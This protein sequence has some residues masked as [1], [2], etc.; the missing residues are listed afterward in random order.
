MVDQQSK[1]VIS[2]IMNMSCDRVKF[3]VSD[4]DGVLRGKYISR[5][6][7][8]SAISGG[9][10]FCS[11]VFGWDINDNC[12]DK[13][14]VS[15]L[16]NGYPD[17]F[18]RLDLSTF[19]TIPWENNTPFL[20][21]DFEKD[22]GKPLLV[23]PRQ[24]LKRVLEQ[25]KDMGFNTKFGLEFEWFSFAETP[26]TLGIK[27]FCNPT[28][29]SPG[30]FGY[31]MLRPALNR[32]YFNAIMDT[33]GAFEIGLE[34]FHTET[35]PGVL[36][37][38]LVATNAL[39]AADEAILFK[40]AV[41]EI[42]TSFGL[43]ASFMAKWH[44]NLSGSGGHIHQSLW[45]STNKNNVFFSNKD[46]HK[47]SDIFKYYVAGQVLILPEI[48]PLLA[49]NINSY[50]RFVE[51]CWAPTKM[52]WGVDN[53]TS[54]LRVIPGSNK[55]TRLETRL[56]GSDINPYLAV[57]AALG[58]GLYGIKHKLKLD[59]PVSGD[60]SCDPRGLALS[61]NLEQACAKMTDSSAAVEI[62]GREFVDHFL[63]TRQWECEKFNKAVTN[64]ELERYFEIV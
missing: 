61:R 24:T 40:T 6:K 21:G 12:Y 39:K 10:G 50:K 59:K 48:M 43:I 2:K 60:A 16:H 44:P 57:A 42:A 52:S 47:M 26:Q 49:P 64:Y 38:A 20:L 25:A 15:G 54:A 27:N 62:L 35:G 18:V 31:S 63:Y 22:S 5:D 8:M 32:D 56:G 36:E 41:K 34:S 14:T 11:V 30:A 55:S 1:D 53:R 17:Q 46:S 19:R 45:D 13:G 37:A 51:G 7:F 4:I 29:I 33:M 23:C 3:A 58:A 28:T 9:L